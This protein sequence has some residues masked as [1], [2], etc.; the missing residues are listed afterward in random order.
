MEVRHRHGATRS[1]WGFRGFFSSSQF[2][3]TRRSFSAHTI[4]A[5]QLRGCFLAWAYLI[6][7]LRCLRACVDGKREAQTKH[8]LVGAIATHCPPCAPKNKQNLA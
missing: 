2:R 3:W 4:V 8:A 1:D 5:F 7:R 6:L